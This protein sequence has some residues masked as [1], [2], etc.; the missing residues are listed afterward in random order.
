MTA[1]GV[2]DALPL[3]R[4]ELL[5]AIEKMVKC[6]AMPEVHAVVVGCA[7]NFA[8]LMLY[9]S[10]PLQDEKQNSKTTV[11]ILGRKIEINDFALPP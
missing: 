9:L 10:T 8:L 6:Y 1:I 2:G 11:G 5:P 3:A 4:R 7:W